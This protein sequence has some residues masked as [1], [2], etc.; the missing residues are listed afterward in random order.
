[1]TLQDLTGCAGEVAEV[2]RQVMQNPQQYGELAVFALLGATVIYLCTP[3]GREA[4]AN[5]TNEIVTDIS[6]AISKAQ[7]QAKEKAESKVYM[8]Y[9]MTNDDGTVYSGRTSGY[10]NPEDIL[11][12][13]HSKHHMAAKGFYNV[14]PDKVA[15]GEQEKL[16]IRGREQQ[17]IDKNGGAQ[18]DTV[19]GH[20]GTSGNAIRGVSKF[21]PKGP[22]YHEAANKEFGNIASYTGFGTINQE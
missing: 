6:N 8:T 9:T 12:K 5:V 13:R 10:G 11:G 2:S 4:V 3:E 18:S 22:V 14:K 19:N 17:L 15:Y 21:N 1:M 7:A 16:A 20:K